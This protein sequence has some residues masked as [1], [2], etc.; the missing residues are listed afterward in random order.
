MALIEIEDKIIEIINKGNKEDFIYDFLKIYDIPNSTITRLKKG[1]NNLSK[2]PGEVHLKNKLYFKETVNDVFEAF[3][4]IERKVNDA[5]AIPRYLFVTNFKVIL[6]KDTKTGESLDIKF[7]ELPIHFNFFLAWNGIEKVDFEKENPLD[8]KAAER[9]ARLFDVLNKEIESGNEEQRH[10]LNLFLMRLLFCLFAEDTNIFH[11]KGQFTNGIKQYTSDDG[12]DLNDYIEGLF[13]VLDTQSREETPIIYKDFPYVNGQLFTE[14]HQPIKFNRKARKLILECGELLEWSKINPD[15]FGSMIQAV[16]TEDSRSH[17]GMHYTSVSNIMKVINPLFLDEVKQQFKE[18]KDSWNDSFQEIHLGKKKISDTRRKHLDKIST[19]TNRIKNMKFFDPACGSGNFLIITYKELRQLEIDIYVLMNE[20]NNAQMLIYEPIV[21]LSQFYGI[22][23]DEFASDI[24]KLSL[25]IAEHQMNLA[26][27]EAVSEAIRPTLPLKSAGDIR[28]GNALRLDWNEV[29][30]HVSNDEVYLFGNPPYKGSK[31]QDKRQKEDLEY[32]FKDR[33]TYKQLDYISGWFHIGS[34]Y[35]E[36]TTSKIGFVSTNSICQGVQVSL[37]WE[38]LLEVVSISYAH[39]SFKWKNNAQNNAGVTVVIVGLEDKRNSEGKS[40]KLYEGSMFKT[41]DNIT[42]Y[43]TRGKTVIVSNKE[44]S[45]SK[46]PKM[47]FGSMPRDGGALIFTPEEYNDSINK[48]PEL[49]KVLWK[50]IGAEEF[51]H[52]GLRYCLWLNQDLYRIYRNNPI[53]LSRVS[54]VAISRS[55]SKASSTKKAAETPFQFVQLGPVN[56]YSKEKM[57][58]SIVV[59]AF[60][61]ENRD[62]LP[63]GLGTSDTIFSNKMYII[64]EGDL[65]LMA[66]LMSRMHMTWIRAI[67]GRL[68]TRYGY[69][70]GLVYNTF[71]IPTLSKEKKNILK[72]LV[73]DILDLRE[74]AG[75]SLAYLYDKKTMPESLR[76]AHEKLDSEV[77][78]IYKSTSFINDE[79]R[80]EKLLELYVKHT[81]ED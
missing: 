4:E 57:R 22:E 74:E 47:E 81:K 15:I 45:I 53:V 79:E 77:D 17:L 1:T 61:S 72:L 49:K 67:A 51:I 59:P 65:S 21:T 75:K 2:I 41:V 3:I 24:A 29:C 58:Y 11:K 20:I 13:K 78:K 34:K 28:C 39:T 26:L 30:P 9:F 40:K 10:A 23:I 18:I 7:K 69:S 64:P 36:N 73:L 71:Y 60:S 66:I 56:F 8:I 54:K 14:P 55:A 48:F 19:L 5:A 33:T 76:A 12:N 6:A 52:G 62:Y 63:I 80:L 46:L 27:K 25:W 37:L 31:K 16:A 50:Y 43:L 38:S 32:A 44:N 70:S 68:E 35:I 42:P